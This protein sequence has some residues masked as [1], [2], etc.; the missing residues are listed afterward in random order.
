MTISHGSYQ[1]RNDVSIIPYHILSCSKNNINEQPKHWAIWGGGG[2][3]GGGI[4][5]ADH[6]S[7][8]R[9]ILSK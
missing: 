4:S 5:C 6:F 8:L 3:G 2:G 9:L 7:F 1:I